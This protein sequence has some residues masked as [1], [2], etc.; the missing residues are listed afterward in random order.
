MSKRRLRILFNTNALWSTSGYGTQIRDLAP[1]IKEAG[2]DIAVVCFYGLE[3]GRIQIDGIT[4]YPKIGDMWGG[5]A[6]VAHQEHFKSDV[7]FSLQD[8]WVLQPQHIAGF[9]RWIPIV[10]IDHE[11]AP[12]AILDRLRSAYRI[13]SYSQFGHDELKRHGF[14]STYIP[15]TVNT[16]IMKPSDKK[17]V[18]K[19]ISIPDDIYLFGMVAAN[20]DNPPRKSFQRAL[21]A[22]AQFVK[23]HPQSGIYFHTLLNQEGGFPIERYAKFLGIEKHIYY[24]PPY[25]LL[26]NVDRAGMARL[27]SMMDCLLLPSTNEGFG[28]PAIEAQSCGVPAIVN[29]FT[30]MPELVTPETGEICEINQKRFTPLDSYVA[31]PD[32]NSLYQCMEKIYSRSPEKMSV[33][34]RD[35]M[36]DKYDL[37]KV[38]KE[39]WLPFLQK[40]EAEIVE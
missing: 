4:C 30:S 22:F 6:V 18:R 26:Y 28:V 2:F 14:H 27:Y 11:P 29:N 12:R 32:T 17:E 37:Q 19:S 31:E 1:L 20:K 3:G 34:C 16:E 10:P 9:R 23:K 7:V 40:L 25:D 38:F 8:I 39:N 13:V 5:D 15:H 35:H 33:A 24:I 36:I 21:D